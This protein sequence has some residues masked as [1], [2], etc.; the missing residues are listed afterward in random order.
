MDNP[1]ITESLRS[2][3]APAA[4]AVTILMVAWRPLKRGAA[5]PPEWLAPLTLGAALIAGRIISVGWNGLWPQDTSMRYPVIFA[6]AAA[7]AAVCSLKLLPGAAKAIGWLGAS[8]F[9]AF[10]LTGHK[11]RNGVWDG[12]DAALW[13]TV[14]GVLIALAAYGVRAFA[15]EAGERVQ[16]FTIAGLTAVLSAVVAQAYAAPSSQLLGVVSAWFGMLFGVSLL[17]PGLV[18]KEAA[19]LGGFVIGMLLCF[20][21]VSGVG[22]PPRIGL[23]L[24]LLVPILMG[25]GVWAKWLTARSE[26][27][28]SILLA[29]GAALIG[30]LAVWST[31]LATSGSSAATDDPYA[32]MYGS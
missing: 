27:T 23:G 1:F 15:S 25:A 13:I 6:L 24:A 10:A 19:T 9:A 32:D 5:L 26:M 30:G 4:G 18:S 20:T 28:R 7:L 12:G 16:K 17:R 3:M 11:V 22:E 21:Y 29:G 8:L 31:Y 14:W 2:V